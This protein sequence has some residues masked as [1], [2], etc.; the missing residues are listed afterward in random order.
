[1]EERR[2]PPE[3]PGAA[4]H[5]FMWEAGKETLMGGGRDKKMLIATVLVASQNKWFETKTKQR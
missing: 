4:V 2:G 5:G 3:P 1:M